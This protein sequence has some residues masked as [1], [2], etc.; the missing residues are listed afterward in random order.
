MPNYVVTYDINGTERTEEEKKELVQDIEDILE[1]LDLK[2][3]FSNQTTYFGRNSKEPNEF[4]NELLEQIDIFN[5]ENDLNTNDAITIY[6]PRMANGSANIRK[7]QIK[8]EGEKSLR[9][10]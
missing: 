10:E 8:R 2:P 3:E 5:L 4:I 9:D 1:Y 6:Y 7:Y